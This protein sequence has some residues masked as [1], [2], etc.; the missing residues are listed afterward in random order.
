[1]HGFKN[2][3]ISK[4]ILELSENAIDTCDGQVL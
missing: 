4:C 2:K 3:Y 1:M